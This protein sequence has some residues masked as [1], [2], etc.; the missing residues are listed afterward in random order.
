M[1][2]FC[3]CKPRD[4]HNEEP[5]LYHSVSSDPT[6]CGVRGGSIPAIYADVY[7][8]ES[9]WM[10]SA[11][12]HCLSELPS[13]FHILS[14]EGPKFV[15]PTRVK[16]LEGTLLTSS[17]K[18]DKALGAL[19]LVQQLHRLKIAQEAGCHCDANFYQLHRQPWLPLYLLWPG[20]QSARMQLVVTAQHPG[21]SHRVRWS[22]CSLRQQKQIRALER[23]CCGHMASTRGPRMGSSEVAASKAAHMAKDPVVPRARSER[24][25]TGFTSQ[26]TRSA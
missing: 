4:H 26:S 3:R 16:A 8:K 2:F 7:Q 10:P 19:G 11:H 23:L 25:R 5:V 12:F 24:Q 18:A 13:P 20:G 17:L 22:G 9:L 1:F 21:A 6:W 15:N 14:C